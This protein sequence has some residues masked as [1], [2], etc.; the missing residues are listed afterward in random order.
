MNLAVPLDQRPLA[1]VLIARACLRAIDPLGLGVGK[2]AEAVDALGDWLKGVPRD[3]RSMSHMLYDDNE[4][5]VLAH[6]YETQNTPAHD[7]WLT[8]SGALAYGTWRVA[9]ETNAPVPSEVTEVDEGSFDEMM[10]AWR[11]IPERSSLISLVA[12]H[13]ENRPGKE[14]LVDLLAHQPAR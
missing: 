4:E 10:D 2:A 5:G 12:V 14:A 8:L 9:K 3:A 6:E 13:I 1:T 7:S 11:E